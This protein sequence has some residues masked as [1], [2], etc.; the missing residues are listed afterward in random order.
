MMATTLSQVLMLVPAGLLILLTGFFV[1]A[2]FALV[3]VR[4]TRIEELAAQN[5]FGAR[6]TREALRQINEYLSATQLGITIAT[7][8]LGSFGEG[9]FEGLLHP[10]FAALP[11]G[12][13]HAAAQGTSL[14]LVVVLEVVIGEMAPKTI[15]IQRAERVALALIYP[16][17][18]F[19]R[20]FR[21]LIALMNFLAGGVLRPFGLRLSGGHDH[22]DTHT[23]AELRL[24]L[25]A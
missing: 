17:D 23:E 4:A 18:V 20:V 25:E 8:T 9:V 22:A 14:L 5:R 21:P 12:F 6:K 2:E 10:A 13:R 15:A 3:K 11:A 24:I 1:A 7:L 19:Y 16:L